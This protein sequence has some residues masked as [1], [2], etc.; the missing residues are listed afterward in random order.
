MSA[1]EELL[2]GAY[3]A[4]NRQDLDGLLALVSEDVDWPDGSSR[5]R[6]RAAVR[7]YWSD[8]WTRTRSHDQPVA[9][10]RRPDGSVAVP[11]SQVIR[12]LDGSVI[13]TGSFC[14]VHRI[15]GSHI[16]RMDIEEA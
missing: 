5:L 3:L 4:Y 10:T 2:S 12:S 11:I 1:E 14:H 8:Q 13:S 9:F 15:E 16:A 7:A 6:G